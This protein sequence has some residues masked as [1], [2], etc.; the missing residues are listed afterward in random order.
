M[1]KRQVHD[2][3]DRWFGERGNFDK[4]EI[5]VR[6]DAECVFDA[7]N[8]Y[9]FTTGS[10]QADFRYADAFVDTGLSGDGASLGRT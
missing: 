4:V 7:H 8:A 6:G 1:Y 9:L 3:A 5:G 2:L 10:D